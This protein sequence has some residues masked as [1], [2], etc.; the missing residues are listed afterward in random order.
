MHRPIFIVGLPA[1]GKTTFGRALARRMG[2]TFIDLDFYITQRF[3]ASVHDI[4]AREGEEGFRHKESAMLREAGEMEDVVVACG[5]GT[6]CFGSNMDYMLS[7]GLT[8]WLD[9]QSGRL[10]ERLKAGG[11][12]R[13]LVSG[14]RE[15][16]L[17]DYVS[18][19][20]RERQPFYSRA[21]IKVDGTHLENRSQIE[22]TVAAFLASLPTLP[23]RQ[24]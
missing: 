10:V 5:G 9:T 2:W 18:R 17:A 21:A 6:P 20:A 14:L 1:S 22:E 8:V 24:R 16:E 15:E 11:S 3:R 12:R 23:L 13:P 4:F 19:T 7:R